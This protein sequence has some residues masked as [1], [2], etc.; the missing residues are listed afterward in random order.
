MGKQQNEVLS[1]AVE[2]RTRVRGNSSDSSGSGPRQ[3]P[4]SRSSSPVCCVDSDDD[5]ELAAACSRALNVNSDVN[6][7]NTSDAIVIEDGTETPPKINVKD[8]F[9]AP[10]RPPGKH[11]TKY[12]DED[13]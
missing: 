2:A 11:W 9:K 13:L 6:V 4:C 3:M 7:T 12:Q 8:E 1:A 5:K 10:S